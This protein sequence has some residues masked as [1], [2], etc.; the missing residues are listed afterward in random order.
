MKVFIVP[1]RLEQSEVKAEQVIFDT[2]NGG[3]KYRITVNDDG[4]LNVR[5]VTHRVLTITPQSANSV[6]IGATDGL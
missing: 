5:E 1:T 2:E 6:R 3:P 4:T